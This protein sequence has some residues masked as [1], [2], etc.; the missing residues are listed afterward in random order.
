MRVPG[1]KFFVPQASVPQHI[2]LSTYSDDK[3]AP[4]ELRAGERWRLTLRLKQPH[5]TAN[6]HGFDFEMW[7]LERNIRAVGYV[8]NKGDNRRID[9]LAPNT[10]FRGLGY[11]IE[12]WREAVRDKFDATLGDAPYAGVLSALAIGDQNS[13]SP[14]QW[15]IFTRTG[16]NHLMSISGLHIT[17]LASLAFAA[18]Y[19]LWR[20]PD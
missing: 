15:Q 12:T 20:Q 4:L 8:H 14:P 5:G 7:A 3:T 19:W 17:M 18:V 2:Y 11:R 13:I 1:Q 16:V 6:P 10:L 9:E